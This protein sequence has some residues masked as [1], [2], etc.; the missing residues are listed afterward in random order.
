MRSRSRHRRYVRN[1]AAGVC[2]IAFSAVSSARADLGELRVYSPVIET[3]VA[4]LE[5]RGARS[6]DSDSSKNGAE[7]QKVSLGFAL[8]DWWSAEVYSQ[9]ARDPGGSLHFDG[10]EW[11][12]FF[13]LTE[14]GEYWANFGLQVEYERVANR[15]ADSDQLAIGPMIERDIGQT[16]TD[17]NLLLTRQLGPNIQQRGVGL[18]YALQTR[19]RLLPEFQPALQLFGDLGSIS[20]LTPIREH[21]HLIGPG[22]YGRFSLGSIPG[23]I[24]YDAAYLFGV[25]RESPAGVV[26][27]IL[28]Y[29]LP[30]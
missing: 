30:L 22:A 27:L 24:Q 18:R 19:W 11:E 26:K 20:H 4:E 2:A 14:P 13:Q 15:R 6:I 23:Y 29:E 5:Y 25:T 12:S 28:E 7:I 3:G 8:T 10:T 17:L 1:I 21:Q 9:W 16:T